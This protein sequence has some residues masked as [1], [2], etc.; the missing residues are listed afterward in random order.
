MKRHE[1]LIPF[2]RFHRS[3]LFLALMAKKNAPKIKGYPTE[4]SEKINYTHS[5]YT[6]QLQKHFETEESLWE[7]AE[8]H[9]DALGILIKSLRE[10]RKELL[11]QFHGLQ[12]DPTAEQLDLLGKLLEKHVR[13][14]ERKLFQLIQAEL[15]EAQLQSLSSL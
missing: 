2:S 5:F 14:E 12:K 3:C 10:E 1:A 11:K 8:K 7:V 9:S 4:L 6:G 13:N 15:S